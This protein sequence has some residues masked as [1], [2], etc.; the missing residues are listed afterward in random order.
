M[1]LVDRGGFFVAENAVLVGDVRVAKGASIWYQAVVRADM[2]PI[3]IG[4]FT[5]I[6]DGCVL[7]CDPGEDL[8]VG[9][10]VTVGHL[11]VIHARRVGDRCLVGIHSI[12][13]GGAEVGD[14]CLIAAGALVREG[15]KIPPRSVVVGVPGKV[16]GQVTDAQLRDFE[17]RAR[18]YHETARRHAEG[19]ADPKFMSEYDR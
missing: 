8:S 4:E 13:L 9:A 18:R 11:A 5:N 1:K 2:S 15:Q 17:E 14:G 6:Q 16:I 3:T 7:H 10:R 19:K 12:L